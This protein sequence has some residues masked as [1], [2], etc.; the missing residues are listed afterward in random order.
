MKTLSWNTVAR[1][2]K[3]KLQKSQK[4]LKT[5]RRKE[6]IKCGLTERHSLIGRLVI[7]P[8]L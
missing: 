8:E 1:K 6:K 3:L 5:K 2:Q 7:A 4:K